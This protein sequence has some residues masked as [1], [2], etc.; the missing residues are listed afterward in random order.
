MS[1]SRI[2][3][4]SPLR[5]PLWIARFVFAAIR[6]RSGAFLRFHPG[7]H[8]STIPSRK[9]IEAN[10][11]RLF[12]AHDVV[13]GIDLNRDEQRKLLGRLVEFYSSF[14]PAKDPTPG[15]LY[16]YANPMYGFQDAFVLFGMLR[17]FQPK[18]VIEVGSGYSSA[19]ML[20]MSR[21]YLV[22]TKFTFI[23]PYSVT[24]GKVLSSR[25]EGNYELLRTE[26]QDIDLN[27][28]QS[29]GDGDVLFIDTSHSVKIGSD[30]SSILFRILPSLKAGVVIHIHDMYFP[31]EYP[32]EFVLEG[33]TYNELYFVRAFLQYNSTFKI[34][35]SATQMEL[36]QADVFPSDYFKAHGGNTGGAS[37]WLR[38]V[39]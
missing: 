3:F 13:D 10:R 25:P 35:F 36:E 32:E 20:D 22:D 5:I 16:H 37:L 6:E 14:R 27:I 33:R 21:E 15:Q 9:F 1:I 11:E 26:V 12:G 8:G 17:I 24:I 7:Y 38:K 31:W 19:L 23:D 30:V 39:S 18:R 28:F 2:L 29:L 4:N 34:I